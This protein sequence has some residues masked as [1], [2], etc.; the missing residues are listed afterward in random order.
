MSVKI[1]E[2]NGKNI[3]ENILKLKLEQ[4]IKSLLH[5]HLVYSSV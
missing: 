5:N 2:N 4:D 3:T 1:S